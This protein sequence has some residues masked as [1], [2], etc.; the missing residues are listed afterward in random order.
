MGCRMANPSRRQSS[1]KNLRLVGPMNA[2]RGGTTLVRS[3]DLV[4]GFPSVRP[5]RGHQEAFGAIQPLLTSNDENPINPSH[6]FGET[7]TRLQK[8]S[9]LTPTESY[10]KEKH[11]RQESYINVM[12]PGNMEDAADRPCIGPHHGVGV[13]H[14]YNER[15]APCWFPSACPGTK[16]IS[17]FI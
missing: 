11:K 12:Q 13:H 3:S 14:S 17:R 6:L 4:R 9:T 2:Y 15:S 8:K 10:I 16:L 5:E 1:T 7:L